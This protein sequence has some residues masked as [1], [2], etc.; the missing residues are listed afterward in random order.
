MLRGEH[1]LGRDA[2]ALSRE[3]RELA[4]ERIFSDPEEIARLKSKIVHGFQ[5][6]ELEINRALDREEEN[7]VW[8]FQEEEVPP[9]FRDRVEEYYRTLS[10]ERGAR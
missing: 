9:A 4:L 7:L 10:N 8:L 1:S 3:M 5:Q 2:A 6:L